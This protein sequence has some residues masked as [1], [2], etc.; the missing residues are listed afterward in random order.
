ML[1]FRP[2]DLTFN[3]IIPTWGHIH[4]APKGKTEVKGK[5][6]H[7]ITTKPENITKFSGYGRLQ[8]QFCI[9]VCKLFSNYENKQTLGQLKEIPLF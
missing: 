2:T 7:W 9:N 4:K 5:L 8:I 6:W 3:H 1:A